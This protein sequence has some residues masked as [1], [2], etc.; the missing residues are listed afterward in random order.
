MQDTSVTDSLF[1]HISSL[2]IET[3]SL[4]SSK[5]IITCSVEVEGRRPISPYNLS[6]Q[7]KYVH[8]ILY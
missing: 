8:E 3:L 6:R 4:F 2:L 1:V 5:D 7:K